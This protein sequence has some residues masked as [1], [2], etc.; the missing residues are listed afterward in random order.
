MG[1]WEVRAPCT[2]HRK[3]HANFDSQPLRI[4]RPASSSSTTC[5]GCE[6]TSTGQF[7]AGRN[8]YPCSRLR[9]ANRDIPSRSAV[10]VTLPAQA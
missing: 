6:P 1:R 2:S 8:P 3:A 10:W 9:T 5:T 7:R 4:T